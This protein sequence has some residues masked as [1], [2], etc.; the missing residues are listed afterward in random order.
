MQAS[1][2]D[3]ADTTGSYVQRSRSLSLTSDDQPPT[4]PKW[5][6]DTRSESA[7]N[8]VGIAYDV[9]VALTESGWRLG[10]QDQ[11]TAGPFD[12]CRV[13]VPGTEPLITAL[14]PQA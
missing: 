1:H 3:S 12:C 14:I 13:V 7:I 11:A 6:R 4:W 9:R 10:A 5:G 8:D 2:A